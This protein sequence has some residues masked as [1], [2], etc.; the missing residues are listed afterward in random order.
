MKKVYKGQYGYLKYRKF[1]TGIALASGLLLV[2]AIFFTGLYLTGT[3]ANILSVLA[4]VCVLPTAKIG[5]AFF[6]LPFRFP[7]YRSE[8]DEVRLNAAELVTGCDFVMT[9][10]EKRGYVRYVVVTQTG[11]FI[12]TPDKAIKLDELEK[13]V[14]NMLQLYNDRDITVKA[15]N[16]YNTFIKRLRSIT[17]K[18]ELSADVKDS[19]T[20]VLEHIMVLSV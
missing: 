7:D 10:N 11:A 13:S 1:K 6:M 18:N 20:T 12:Y 8:Y 2:L 19:L 4:V 17:A 15:F 3:R 16:D 9:Y 5:V 14:L